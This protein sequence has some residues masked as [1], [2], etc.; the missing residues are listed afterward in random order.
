MARRG[1]PKW[2]KGVSGNPKGARGRRTKKQLTRVVFEK[3][4]SGELKMPL[5]FMLALL[6]APD[7]KVSMDDR[8]WAAMHAAPYCHRKMP[9]AIE[10]GE[11]PIKVFDASRLA[12][13]NDKE[14]KVFMGILTKIGVSELE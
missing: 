13:L 11:S 14:L 4:K 10:G 1:N 7:E 6:T 8:K 9:I 2:V 12:G 5:E 3:I